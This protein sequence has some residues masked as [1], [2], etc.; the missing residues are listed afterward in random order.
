MRWFKL[1]L[2]DTRLMRSRDVA[3]WIEFVERMM[4]AQFNR[5]EARFTPQIH[6]TYLDL[7]AFATAGFF[8]EDRPGEGLLFSSRPLK[9]LYLAEDSAGRV[10]TVF[11]LFKFTAKQAI[12][13]FGPDRVPEAAKKVEEGNAFEKVEILHYVRPN[14]DL[15]EGGF[16]IEGMPWRS[17]YIWKEDPRILGEG[18]YHE[19]PYMTPR[20]SVDSGEVYGRGPGWDALPEQKM[21]NEME[22]TLLITAQKA[23]MPPTLVDNDSVI[24][25]LRLIP[26]GVTVVD[27]SLRDDPVRAFQGGERIDIGVEMMERHRTAVRDA[28]Q[29]DLLQMIR[30]PYLK[31][32][33]VVEIARKMQ[34]L[35]SPILQR[36]Q[37]E[38]LEPIIERVFG[39]LV[40][41]GAVP[42][43]PPEIA[44][45]PL[46]IEYVS[47]VARAQRESDAEAILRTLGDVANLSQVNPDMLDNFDFD[48]AARRVAEDR[49]TPTEI[50][51]D[52]REVERRRAAERE[53]ARQQQEQAEM[54]QGAETAAKVIPAI[55][56]AQNQPQGQ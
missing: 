28:F 33:Q 31:E 18:G 15:N 47:P 22:K 10:D 23:A 38:L 12:E 8:V 2:E 19:M 48:A 24:G 41:Q 1:K 30:Q 52:P 40:R 43:P 42:P 54:I 39:I 49:G 16:G 34:R 17:T 14:E 55:T 13:F 7:V 50:L 35:L 21:L 46:K 37:V 20:W 53:L 11:R 9:E 26:N 29:F 5:P 44:G 6:E 36:Q 56:Q 3:A 25:N 4:Y 32:V 45:A 27:R 51:R